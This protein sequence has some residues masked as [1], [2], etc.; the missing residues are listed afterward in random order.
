MSIGVVIFLL[1]FGMAFW[2][3]FFLMG[4]VG[5]WAHWSLISMIKAFLAKKGFEEEV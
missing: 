3:L 5:L 4:F 1:F 2:I